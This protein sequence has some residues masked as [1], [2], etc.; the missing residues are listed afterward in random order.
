MATIDMALEKGLPTNLDAERY[1][2]GSILLDDTFF[3]Q[4]AAVLE[5]DD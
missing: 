5:P 2:L 1:V 3:V 4:V